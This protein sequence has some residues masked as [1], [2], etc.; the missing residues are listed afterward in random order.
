MNIAR[1]RQ[2]TDIKGLYL[3][4]QDSLSCGFVGALFGGLLCAGAVLG[5][6]VF[7]DLQELHKKTRE[8]K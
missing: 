5:R 7:G 4:G 3:T 8:K 6:N 1:L 2:Q